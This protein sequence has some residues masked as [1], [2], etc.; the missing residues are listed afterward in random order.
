MPLIVTNGLGPSGTV[1]PGGTPPAVAVISPAAGT[2]IARNT[3]LVVE[4]TDT[5]GLRRAVLLMSF[6]DLAEAELVH[7]GDRFTRSY[8]AGSSVSAITGGLRFTLQRSGGWPAAPTL[9]VV[10]YD[11]IGGEV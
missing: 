9:E 7:D 6:A 10:A 1:T 3:P 2:A 5:D 11:I 8:Q 4:V